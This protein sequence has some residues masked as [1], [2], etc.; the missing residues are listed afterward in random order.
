MTSIYM[1]SITTD[2]ANLG[3][4]STQLSTESTVEYVTWV[5]PRQGKMQIAFSTDQGDSWSATALLESESILLSNPQV[6]PLSQTFMFWQSPSQRGCT[7]YGQ[8][9]EPQTS[10]ENGASLTFGALEP[11]MSG[12]TECPRGG[13]FFEVD[14]KWVWVSGSDTSSLLISAL[15]T[16]TKQW[17]QPYRLDISFPNPMTEKNISLGE[18]NVAL[19]GRRIAIVGVDPS[20]R[21]V[22]FV[23]TQVSA[24]Q[25]A[26]APP[27]PW[28]DLMPLASRGYVEEPPDMVIT[29]EGHVHAVWGQA[30]SIRGVAN[31]I[32]YAQSSPN[33]I[34]G[35][36]EIVPAS[37]KDEFALHP[38]LFYEA[39]R[40][41]LHLVWSGG[42]SG[43][44]LHK[45]VRE[46]EAGFP[47]AWSQ[48]RIISSIPGSSRPQLRADRDGNL[49][50]LF[51]IP[52]NEARGVYIIQT[53]DSGRYWSAPKLILDAAQAGYD[54]VDF[55]TMAI[56][57]DNRLHAAWVHAKVPGLGGS[58]A[59]EYAQSSDQGQTWTEPIIL[60]GSGFTR[61]RL[62]LAG[63][64]LHLFF[65][66]ETSLFGGIYHRYVA[67]G[68][69][70]VNS[71]AWN[72]PIAVPG[73]QQISPKYGVAAGSKVYL[74]G[75]D[76]TSGALIYSTWDE[77]R[78]KV[79]ERFEDALRV[80]RGL[81]VSAVVGEGDG[82]LI[83]SW[84]AMPN[85]KNETTPSLFMLARQIPVVTPSEANESTI[86][87]PTV[88]EIT[89]PPGSAAEDPPTTGTELPPNEEPGDTASILLV[90]TP[91]PATQESE[92]L[93]LPPMA[94]GGVLSAVLVVIA[95]TGIFWFRRIS[96]SIALLVDRVK[97]SMRTK[98]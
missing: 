71:G 39:R 76:S 14:D 2:Q 25:L 17:S 4:T 48:A 93:A 61:P 26:Y 80:S 47:A 87:D 92:E 85:E 79:Q 56:G 54:M 55:P 5:D 6:V 34:F 30:T 44:L 83:A 9:I 51:V 53:S 64:E 45:W 43:V 27:S 97:S 65:A 62:A 32:Q 19:D 91:A 60:S 24:I 37:V 89:P 67:A 40:G 42:E 20:D 57:P 7:L 8:E 46:N 73:L 21:D 16:R 90:S 81:G 78:W 69:L 35:P 72:V 66:P 10:T 75:A 41:L 12:L 33:G 13:Q 82:Q 50:V 1:R 95:L 84:L 38:A 23:K 49:Y 28:G 96:V 70:A 3:I 52:V 31:A 74:L 68:E 15:N 94:L 59:V 29:A 63:E 36:I 86:L 58:I 22:W 77:D 18:L 98:P 88:E 11:I